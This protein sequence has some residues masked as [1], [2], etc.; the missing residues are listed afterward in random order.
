MSP[1]MVVFQRVC[2]SM[3]TG[4]GASPSLNVFSIITSFPGVGVKGPTL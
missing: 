4:E 2:P 1:F 3:D